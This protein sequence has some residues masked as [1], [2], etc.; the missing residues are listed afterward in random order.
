[1]LLV[2]FLIVTLGVHS[3]VIHVSCV[4][5][6]LVGLHYYLCSRFQ[7]CMWMAFV[8]IIYYLTHGIPPG[9]WK[10][11]ENDGLSWFAWYCVT[12]SSSNLAPQ[13]LHLKLLGGY[14]FWHFWGIHRKYGFFQNH[15]AFLNRLLRS[16]RACTEYEDFA[17]TMRFYLWKGTFPCSAHHDPVVWSLRQVSW[18]PLPM[19]TCNC[20]F[21]P[22]RL[23]AF[24]HSRILHSR[25]GVKHFFLE[26]LLT[27]PAFQVVVQENGA[28]N[29]VHS[30]AI[31]GGHFNY[32]SEART[33]LPWVRS[34]QSQVTWYDNHNEFFISDHMLYC[35]HYCYDWF[36]MGLVV[37]FHAS[38]H[39]NPLCE[40]LVQFVQLCSRM[41]FE[42]RSEYIV[43]IFTCYATVTL[44]Q[45]FK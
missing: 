1:M 25:K 2:T 38:S 28:H 32:G 31:F 40:Q 37:S 24:H 30:A 26:L 18:F 45:I 34:V 6:H 22:M 27:K 41:A 4:A 29:I 16:T 17:A 36:F 44:C 35:L 5:Q 15:E 12:H 39:S 13:I 11:H 9:I 3:N 14:R 43:W 23:L 33:Y 10:V 42:G 19:N 21:F 7:L 20:V 8:K